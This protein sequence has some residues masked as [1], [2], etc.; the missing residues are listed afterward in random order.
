[1]TLEYNKP[2]EVSQK[3]YTIIMNEYPMTCAGK[4]EAGKYFIKLW[5]M[6]HHNEILKTIQQN[7]LNQ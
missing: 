5:H 4:E 3:A 6:Q 2:I 1:M 7:P